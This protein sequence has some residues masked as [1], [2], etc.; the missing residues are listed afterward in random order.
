VGKAEAKAMRS[1]T[2][3]NPSLSEWC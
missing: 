2:E 3:L 1:T